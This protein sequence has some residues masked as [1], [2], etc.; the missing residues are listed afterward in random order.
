MWSFWLCYC[1]IEP[2]G[3]VL[4][5]PQRWHA[6]Q[7]AVYDGVPARE[8]DDGGGVQLSALCHYSCRVVTGVVRAASDTVHPLQHAAHVAHL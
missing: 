3:V 6:A 1:T 5:R 7:A 4:C 2:F 8:V